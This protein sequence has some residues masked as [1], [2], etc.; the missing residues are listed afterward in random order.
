MTE[1]SDHRTLGGKDEWGG[2]EKRRGPRRQD[3]FSSGSERG[4]SAPWTFLSKG[5]SGDDATGNPLSGIKLPPVAAMAIIK[6]APFYACKRGEERKYRY[7][8]A[9]G[10]DS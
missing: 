6:L 4:F 3:M 2:G 1:T 8:A 10:K 7:S 5:K 9:R